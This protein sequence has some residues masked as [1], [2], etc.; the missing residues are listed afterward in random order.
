ML[1][2]SDMH[3]QQRVNVNC[4]RWNTESPEMSAVALI[5]GGISLPILVIRFVLQR[6]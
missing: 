5:R 4:I 3:P 2:G 6:I 1:C